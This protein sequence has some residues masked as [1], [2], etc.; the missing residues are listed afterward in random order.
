MERGSRP[1]FAYVPLGPG[2]VVQPDGGYPAAALHPWVPV[3]TT[4]VI[5]R[6]ERNA[7]VVAE[8][9]VEVLVIPAAAF[10]RSWSR[11]MEVEELVARLGQAVHAT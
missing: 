11:P 2:L 3:G 1:S 10:A 5:R 7:E 6:A 9:E 8:R 4:G